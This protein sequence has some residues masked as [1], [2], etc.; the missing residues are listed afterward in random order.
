MRKYFFL[1]MVFFLF[2]STSFFGNG[3]EKKKYHPGDGFFVF[4]G[5][6]KNSDG[7]ILLLTK[8]YC[9]R[10][11]INFLELYKFAYPGADTSW[12]SDLEKEYAPLTFIPDKIDPS[13]L[14][15]E[16]V[17]IDYGTLANELSWTVYGYGIYDDDY[18]YTESY[19][20]WPYYLYGAAF[21]IAV[22]VLFRYKERLKWTWRKLRKKSYSFDTVEG[23][24]KALEDKDS[25][26]RGE[27]VEALN[28]LGNSKAIDSLIRVLEKEEDVWVKKAAILHLGELKAKRAVPALLEAL[29]SDTGFIVTASAHSLAL[30]GDR[31]TIEAL[32]EKLEVVKSTSTVREIRNAIKKLEK[33][34]RRK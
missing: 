27:A 13:L 6:D 10:N 9:E 26:V 11:N 2:F 7:S 32:Q 31:K 14:I 8:I 34:G 30:I 18:E 21:I 22:I 33:R 19:S 1:I 5:T 4:E 24:L 25:L 15:D 20:Y 16:L 12:I 3:E 29:H 23:C 17:K 28:N